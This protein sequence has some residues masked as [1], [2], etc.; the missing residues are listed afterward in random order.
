VRYGYH[1]DM[2]RTTALP[3]LSQYPAAPH[4]N[5]QAVEKA[6]GISSR[7]LRSWE[8]RYGTPNPVRDGGGRRLYSERD[9][10]L[11]RWLIDRVE[12]GISIGRAVA[13]FAQ[14]GDEEESSG[15]PPDLDRLQLR[16]LEAIDWMDEEEAAGVLAV[17][18]GGASV[19][20]V[21]LDLI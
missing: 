9:L 16:L 17:A 14:E 15:P 3:D 20:S 18:L 6:T 13:M 12:Q 5:I 10:V 8:R 1:Q 19:E 4:Y 2:D 11:I 21:V 7:T